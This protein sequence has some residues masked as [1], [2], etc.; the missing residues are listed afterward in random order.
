MPHSPI[1]GSLPESA[2]IEFPPYGREGVGPVADYRDYGT[3]GQGAG[4]LRL[5]TVSKTWELAKRLKAGTSTPY[6]YALAVN[7]YL[8]KG[9]KYN[10]K[11]PVAPN[12]QAP[13]QFFLLDSKQ[14]YCQ[15]FSGAMALL[16]RMGGIP[17]RVA[18]GFSPGGYS[19]RKQAWIVRDTDAHSWVEAW[20]E[21]YG[22]VTMDPTPSDTPARSQIATLSPPS[23]T[24]DGSGAANGAAGGAAGSAEANRRAAGSRE[25]L[26]DRL[27]GGA[28]KTATEDAPARS[29]GFPVLPVLGI[30]LLLS[31]AAATVAARRRRPRPS[32]PLDRAIFELETALRRSGRAAPAGMTLR[33]LERR[34]GLSSEAAEYLRAVGAA[35]YG[36]GGAP[37]TNAQRKALRR[38]LA[39]GQGMLGRIRTFWA[40]PPR[41]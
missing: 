28:S 4:V 39:T 21:G 12:G 18:T 3:T 15:H 22:W 30:V 36:A 1:D 38:E 2:V 9:F 16:L 41:R 35:R 26:F 34:L 19:A 40:L 32:D 31:V 11:P 20:F 24:Q 29:G 13:L 27:R 6:E 33:Q 5:S 8:H 7:D 37:P 17:A 25:A 23:A 10:E 14:G